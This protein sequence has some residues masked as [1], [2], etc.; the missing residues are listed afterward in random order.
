[1]HNP[2]LNAVDKS[3]VDKQAFAAQLVPMSGTARAPVT[4]KV[5]KRCTY[6]EYWPWIGYPQK[7]IHLN[8]LRSSEKLFICLFV[9]FNYLDV[10]MSPP[11]SPIDE[12]FDL[13]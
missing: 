9:F 8:S 6:Y 7:V 12:P 10:L 13:P 3:P 11:L 1:M 2:A 5:V 4:D